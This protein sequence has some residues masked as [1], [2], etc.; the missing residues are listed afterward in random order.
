VKRGATQQVSDESP[1]NEDGPTLQRWPRGGSGFKA[2]IGTNTGLANPRRSD[3]TLSENS[4]GTCSYCEN[5]ADGLDAK[6][7]EPICKR[8]ARFLPEQIKRSDP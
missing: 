5:Y 3:V 4:D 2:M 8:C 1:G 7:S 6:R